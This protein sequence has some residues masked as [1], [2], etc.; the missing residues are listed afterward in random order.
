MLK[1][2]LYITTLLLLASV[3]ATAFAETAEELKNKIDERAKQIQELETQIQQY[4][5]EVEQTGKEAKTLQSTIKTLDLTQ[6]KLTTDLTL[7][8]RKINLANLTIGELGDEIEKTQNHIDTNKSAIAATLQNTAILEDKSMFEVILSSKNMTEVWNDIE[9]IRQIRNTIRVKSNE[10]RELEDELHSKQNAMLGEKKQLT[11]LKQDLGGKKQAVELTKKE[12]ADILKLTKNKEAA[13]RQLVS[14]TE[15]RKEQFEK[16]M[17]EFESKLKLLIDPNSYPAPKHG[18]FSWPLDNVYVTQMFGKTVGASKL[19][20]SGSHNGIDFR[21]SVGTRV[22]NMLDGVVVGSGNTDVYP[23]C[24]SFGKWVMVK[25]DNGLSSI[26]AHLSSIAITNG[27][28]L[29]TG[30]VVGYSGNTGYS[31]GPH[32]HVSVY[33]TQGVRI[34]QFVNSRG[35]KQA[36]IPLADIRAYL[37]PMHYLPSY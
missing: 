4:N 12:K 33:A 29:S 5:K 32:L 21:A 23:G 13:F 35:C 15:E 34:E 7:T 28:K 16:E 6:K 36:V 25:H 2:L 27:Q 19:Y 17:F 11:T 37:D 8:E 1:K 14:V 24:Y 9:S 20:V 22:K 31:T 18:I 30:D 26:Y 3:S 10:L